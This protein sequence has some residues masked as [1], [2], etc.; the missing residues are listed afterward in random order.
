MSTAVETPKVETPQ[1][2]EQRL[3]AEIDAEYKGMFQVWQT[4]DLAALAE[5][6]DA[7]IREQVQL[8]VKDYQEKQKPLTQEQ[9]QKMLDQEYAEIPLT[10]LVRAKNAETPQKRTYTVRELPQSVERK[11]YKQFVSVI[12]VEAPKL[13]AL[14]Q[15]NMDEPFEIVL[16]N[17]LESLDSGFDIMAGAVALILNPFGDDEEITKEWVSDNV[18]SD[19]QFKII[20][21]QVEANKLRDFFSRVFLDGQKALM[22]LTPQNS[23]Q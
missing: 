5:K 4:K 13:A 11:F 20:M 9:I 21:A 15:R 14:K 6:Q 8:L 23:R 7:T 10:L 2:M 1:E 12:R 19:R 18:S 3:R 16:M 17:F 22:S